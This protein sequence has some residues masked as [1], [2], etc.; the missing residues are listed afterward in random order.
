MGMHKHDELW[1]KARKDFPHDPALQQV[2]YAR[3]RIHE[4]TKGLSPAEYIEYIRQK[5]K[6][7]IQGSLAS[8][9][10]DRT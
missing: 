9:R 8:K 7:V 5:A 2:H 1:E 3:L 6:K 4:A 10:S